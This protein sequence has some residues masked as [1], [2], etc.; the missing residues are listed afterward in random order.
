[1]SDMGLMLVNPS[2]TFADVMRVLL[3][4]EDTAANL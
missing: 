3:E 4:V 2:I 1:M